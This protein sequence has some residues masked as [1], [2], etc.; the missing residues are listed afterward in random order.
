MKASGTFR[1]LTV[2]LIGFPV[3]YPLGAALVFQLPLKGLGAIVI[4]PLFYVATVLWIATGK[5]L[6]SYRHWSWYTFLVA[7]A[8]VAWFNAQI[9]LNYS[10]SPFKA[11][12]FFLVLALQLLLI[13]FVS[14]E[15]RV[16][17]LFPR[18]HW[19]KSGVESIRSLEVRFTVMRETEVGLSARILD[20]S[21]RGCFL[22]TPLD[23]RAGEQVS[24]QLSAYGQDLVVK[25]EIVWIAPSTVTH[26]RGIGIRFEELDRQSRRKIRTMA[27]SF[28]Q[29]K[30]SSGGTSILPS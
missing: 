18:I 20:L 9:V 4:S 28:D 14:R 22:K 5:G 17:Y 27:R 1:L 29:E 24:L 26:P 11:Y 23:F 7:Q 21:P 8:I 12:S 30:E 6:Q 16:P 13:R 19:W 3:I 15:V 2:F 25:G 10:E